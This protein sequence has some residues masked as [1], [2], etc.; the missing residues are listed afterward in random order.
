[1][2]K[3]RHAAPASAAPLHRRNNAIQKDFKLPRRA[4]LAGQP[5]EFVLDGGRLWIA[6]KHGEQGHGRAQPAQSD[7]HLMHP[8]GVTAE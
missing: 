1:M 4:E 2:R 8:F 6:Q 7:A 3:R 5:F